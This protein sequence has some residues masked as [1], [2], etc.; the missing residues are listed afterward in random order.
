MEKRGS[1]VMGNWKMNGRFSE[2]KTLCDHLSS[3]VFM[4]ESA[5]CVPF[6]YLDYARGSLGS[7]ISLGA[8]NISEFDQGAYTG[9]VS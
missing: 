6:P 9:E 7:Q 3:Q 8:Q 2:T 4:A 1:L 5:V